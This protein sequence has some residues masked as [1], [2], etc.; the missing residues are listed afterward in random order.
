[1]SGFIL[2]KQT[3]WLHW[4]DICIPDCAACSISTRFISCGQGLRNLVVL[5]FI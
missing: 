5:R 1:M 2:D 3:M 4:A